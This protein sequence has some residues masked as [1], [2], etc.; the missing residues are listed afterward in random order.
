M[1]GYSGAASGAGVQGFAAI[2]A[3]SSILSNPSASRAFNIVC[4]CYIKIQSEAIDV[5]MRTTRVFIKPFSISCVKVLSSIR[6]IVLIL[7]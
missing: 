4:H 1:S 6:A 7:L 2:L 3:K 5:N